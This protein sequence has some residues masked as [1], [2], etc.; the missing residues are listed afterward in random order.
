MPLRG[1]VIPICKGRTGAAAD[2][3]ALSVFAVIPLPQD[4]AQSDDH[5]AIAA[6]PGAPLPVTKPATAVAILAPPRTAGS[7]DWRSP[8]RCHR[9]GAGRPPE[10]K[11]AAREQKRKRTR[12]SPGMHV[13]LYFGRR[14]VGRPRDP[15][16]D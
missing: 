14:F 8:R 2:R 5:R 16:G 13:R 11:L 12:L 1:S 10:Q 7:M 3:L 9:S 4:F 6:E 15:D